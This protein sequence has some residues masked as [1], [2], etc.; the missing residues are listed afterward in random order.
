MIPL[1]CVLAVAAFILLSAILGKK[2]GEKIEPEATPAPTEDPI[3]PTVEALKADLGGEFI[4]TGSF[5]VL[6][7]T[8]KVDGSY[9]TV[10]VYGKNEVLSIRI[11]RSLY[12]EPEP[13]EDPFS[14]MFEVVPTPIPSEKADSS[15]DTKAVAGEICA[16]LE[17]AYPAPDKDQALRETSAALDRLLV[18]GAKKTSIVYG[19]YVVEFAY[20]AVDCIVTVT[21]EPA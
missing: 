12:A 11:T 19:I 17:H 20:S 4:S 7:Y 14:D 6:S 21:C 3:V 13:T 8:S 18:D 5:S 16:V 1:V 9:G 10:T 2:S 15:S